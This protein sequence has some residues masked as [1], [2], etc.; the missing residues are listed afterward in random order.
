[1]VSQA[2]TLALP[3]LAKVMNL[4]R[5]KDDWMTNHEL[6][7]DV[8]LG[9]EFKFHNIFICPVSKEISTKDNP[10]MLLT[11]G[12]AVSKNSLSRMVRGT[13]RGKFKCMTCPTEMTPDKVLEMKIN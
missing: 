8:E 12:H 3:R 5:N 4:I 10:P 2:S 1:M 11:C 9:R 13:G 7:I 6:P